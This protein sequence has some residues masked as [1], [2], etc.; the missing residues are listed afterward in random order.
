MPR[1]SSGT[2]PPWNNSWIGTTPAWETTHERK[3][4]GIDPERLE[5]RL[6]W[7]AEQLELSPDASPEDVR[8]AWLRRLPEEDF[9]PRAELQSALASLLRRRPEGNWE[10]RADE[11]ASLAEEESLR[12]EVET[13]AGQFW[14]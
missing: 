14:D 9:V 10:A 6:R 11:A 2:V 3:M 7:A 13:F 4:T 12:E 5:R 1:R 8:A